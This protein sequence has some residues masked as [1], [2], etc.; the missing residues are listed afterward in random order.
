MLSGLDVQEGRTLESADS[1]AFLSVQVLF[2]FL[3][4]YAVCKDIYCGLGK[5]RWQAHLRARNLIS[6]AQTSLRRRLAPI[7]RLLPGRDQVAGQSVIRAVASVDTFARGSVERGERGMRLFYMAH[8][9]GLVLLL[10]L[11]AIAEIAK[12]YRVL[13]SLIDFL[14]M[15]Y[16]AFFSSWFRSK[17]IGL[18]DKLQSRRDH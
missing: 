5:L 9:V 7:S 11:V 8:A 12:G 15:S 3:F 2:I 10:Q 18:I 14:A 1:I 17:A 6:R 4:V 16:L 13:L